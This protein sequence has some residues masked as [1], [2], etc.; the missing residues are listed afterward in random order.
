[1]KICSF[2]FC[3][4]L[5][6]STVAWAADKNPELSMIMESAGFRSE[7]VLQV[8]DMITTAEQHGLPA[9]KIAG[10]VFEGIAKNVD[11]ER[12]IQ[13]MQRV[14]D[15][16]EYGYH[17]AQK[18]T[19]NK[20]QSVALG[21]TMVGS[22]AA[23][24]TRQ[25]AEKI[26]EN[27]RVRSENMNKNASSLL[28]QETIKTARDLCR[29]GVSSETAE[30]ILGKAARKGFSAEDMT[31]FR[32]TFNQQGINANHE[33]LA[34]NYGRAID[35]GARAQDLEAHGI[36]GRRAGRG[37]NERQGSS[38]GSDG[39]GGSGGSGDSGGS[40]GGDAGDSGGSGGS[41]GGDTG[42]SGG[43]GGSGGGDAGGSGGSGGGHH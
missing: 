1:M 12:I 34:K 28:A 36:E 30:D 14:V 19:K 31:T 2:T 43:S 26:V 35:Q 17:L 42:G 18:L 11:P 29:Q 21:N 16:Y 23:G 6:L 33:S 24:L 4:F 3:F 8:E 40:G 20:K 38:N 15:R 25:D 41:G 9:D 39:S 5:F 10:K 22:M 13:A 32:N 37:S 27:L 7:Q